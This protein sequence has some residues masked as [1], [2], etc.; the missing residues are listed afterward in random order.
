MRNKGLILFFTILIALIC[1]YCL[2]FTF[3]TTSV[4]NKA[5][6]FAEEVVNSPESVQMIA[7]IA[8]GDPMLEKH[9]GDSIFDANESHFLALM[10][11]S[12]VF[13]GMTYKQ[14]K[15]KELNLGLGIRRQ[16]GYYGTNN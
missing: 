5:K 4:E 7:Q 11:D 10:K 9:L 12:T 14:C 8:A 2:S 3:V 15:Y 13:L 16:E 1:V 6:K